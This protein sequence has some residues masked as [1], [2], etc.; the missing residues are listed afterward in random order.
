MY[1]F[2]IHTSNNNP[3]TEHEHNLCYSVEKEFFELLLLRK[4]TRKVNMLS[5]VKVRDNHLYVWITFDKLEP[6][7]SMEFTSHTDLKESLKKTLDS[8]H[9]PK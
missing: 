1:I 5:F 9:I 2:T 3:V 8:F 4:I 6:Q 7:C